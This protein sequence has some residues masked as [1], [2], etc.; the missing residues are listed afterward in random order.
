MVASLRSARVDDVAREL[1][2]GIAGYLRSDLERILAAADERA[3]AIRREIAETEARRVVAVEAASLA[4]TQRQ[5]IADAWVAA[6]QQAEAVCARAEAE[7]QR[8]LADADREA[9]A[10]RARVALT[11]SAEMPPTGGPTI[12]NA[13]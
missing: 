2:D 8:I 6:H 9:R 10:G 7:A 13:R 1:P 3:D 12:W 11:S 4:A 5:R